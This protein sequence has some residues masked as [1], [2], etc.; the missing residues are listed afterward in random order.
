MVAN[1]PLISTDG[2]LLHLKW[3]LICTYAPRLSKYQVCLIIVGN[4][5]GLHSLLDSMGCTYE[6]PWS[7]GPIISTKVQKSKCGE[8][9]SPIP[10]IFSFKENSGHLSGSVG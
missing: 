3:C 6:A 9:C 4:Q 10:L 1:L 7:Y 2:L 5:F 8:F